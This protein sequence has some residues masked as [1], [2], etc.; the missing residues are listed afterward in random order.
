MKAI[1]GISLALVMILGSTPLVFSESLR[2]QMD[3]GI[4]TDQIQCE[5]P[6]QVLVK[7]TNGKLACVT[8]KTAEKLN[9]KILNL[10]QKISVNNDSTNTQIQ[11]VTLNLSSDV[12]FVD[13]GREIKRS[14]LQ[15]SPMPLPMY[16]RIMAT[17]N[18]GVSVSPAGFA[19]FATSSHEKYSVNPE[20]G[21]YAE[22]WMPGYIPDGQKLLYTDKI[23]YEKS[24]DCELGI[25]FVPTNF[26]LHENMT[27]HDLQVSK[28]F[29]ISVKYSTLPLG[30]V[31]NTIEFVKEIRESQPRNFGLG[32]VNM[33]HDGNTVFAY[34]GGNA[35]NHYSAS[36]YFHPDDHISVGV[37]SYYLT[38]DELIPIFE[39]VM[40]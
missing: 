28:G 24:G 27:S 31:E 26:V 38:L 35:L 4:K 16:D 2:I 7:R 11:L 1:L 3:D 34:E 10:D 5:N 15:K 29:Y 36:L 12:E 18:D 14:I 21:F 9:W 20:T 13:D 6:N 37:A 22:D 17:M 23:C 8:E 30:E 39:S 25:N 19:T 32:F 40:K 33:T